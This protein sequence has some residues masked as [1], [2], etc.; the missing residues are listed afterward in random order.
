MLNKPNI[1][2]FCKDEFHDYLL[3]LV[4]RDLQNLPPDLRCRRRDLAEAILACNKETGERNKLKDA[5][6]DAM[7]NWSSS[8]GDHLTK[9]GFIT[10]KGRT[11]YKLKRGSYFVSISASPSDRRSAS[12]TR[13][14][15]IRTF[16]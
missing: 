9:Y 6:S 14:D 8:T 12:N 5:V 3:E 13:A 7:M 2:E 4:K 10:T 16:F 11:H 15:A 1:E